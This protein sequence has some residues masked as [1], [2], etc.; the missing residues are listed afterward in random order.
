[1]SFFKQFAKPT[2]ELPAYIDRQTLIDEILEGRRTPR[3]ILGLHRTRDVVRNRLFGSSRLYDI[4]RNNFATAAVNWT[5]HTQKAMLLDGTQTTGSTG[6]WFGFISGATNANPVVYTYSGMNDPSNNDVLVLGGIGGNLSA[7]Q[8]GLC[9]S[10]NTGA[11]TFS[12][13]TLEPAG[14]GGGVL[15]VAG[16]G[17]YTATTGYAM[18]L[19]QASTVSNILGTRVG[20]DVTL[21]GTSASRGVCTCTSPFTWSAVASGNTASFVI[22]YDANGGTDATNKLEGFLDG[23]TLIVIDKAVAVNDTTVYIEPAKAAINHTT[24]PTL[25]FS[26]GQALTLTADVAQG[27]R[28]LTVS[29]A[30]AIIAAGNQADQQASA[31]GI[32]LATNNG[33]ISFSVGSLYFPTTPTGLFAL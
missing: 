13:T 3:Q 28:T 11:K 22:L 17:V 8:I 6:T 21:S 30:A 19:T 16:S 2:R 15:N 1:V 29:A 33:N 27:D 26:N 20:T 4:G 14:N 9:T 5:G 10:V 24:N 32:P 12:L 31:A 23:K 25:N 7:N 18:N